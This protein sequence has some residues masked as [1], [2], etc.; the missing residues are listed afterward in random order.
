MKNTII[1]HTDG[2]SRGNPGPA[3][4]GVVIRDT[5]GRVM[6]SFGKAIGIATNNE[7]EYQAIVAALQKAKS[8]IGGKKSKETAVDMRMDSQLAARQ[9]AGKYKIEE[10]RL[11]PHFIKIWNLK[12]DF[13]CV[14]FT[15]VPREEN[16]DADRMVNQA[17]DGGQD[18]LF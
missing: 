12:T 18:P 14:S 6:K 5:D 9:L 13:A 3:A 17:L 15:H 8:L 16:K 10:E 1:I 11:W 4:I 2:G 7:A